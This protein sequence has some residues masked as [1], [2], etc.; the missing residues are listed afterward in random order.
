MQGRIIYIRGTTQAWK[1]YR[2]KF[3][4]VTIYKNVCVSIYNFYILK[5]FLFFVLL[6]CVS[7]WSVF[8]KGLSAYDPYSLIVTL[9]AFAFSS[10]FLCYIYYTHF[11]FLSTLF[12]YF[13]LSILYFSYI[14]TLFRT[15]ILFHSLCY[16]YHSAIF[17]RILTSNHC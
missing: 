14:F 4:F 2:K 15:Q 1:F 9:T 11:S 8:L 3:F 12:F 17:L 13:C 6:Q 5:S 16:H 7:V 10:Q